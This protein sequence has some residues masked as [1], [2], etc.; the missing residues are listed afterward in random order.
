MSKNA[1]AAVGERAALIPAAQ[2]LR[3][4]SEVQKYS[5]F[6]Q[7]A[8]IA[9]FSKREGYEIVRTYVDE[10][11]SGISTKGRKGLSDMLADIVAGR[12]EYRAILVLDVSRWGRYQDP[13]EAAH[14]EFL[15]RSSGISVRYVAE[16]FDENPT[17]AILKQLK[18]VMAG[19]YSRELSERIRRAKRINRALGLVQGGSCPYGTA[20]QEL[21]PDGSL[22]KVLRRGE[23][24][25]HPEYR[26]RY[27]HGDEREIGVV[28]KIFDLYLVRKKLPAQIAR[29]LQRDGATW[30]SG[31]P[32]TFQHVRRVLT[33]EL[34]TGVLRFGKEAR[35]FGGP[36][37]IQP[38]S[39]WGEVRVMEP[40][41]PPRT[42]A[43]AQRR[44]A[45]LADNR[46]RS[47]ERMLSDLRRV[48]DRVGRLSTSVVDEAP[49]CCNAS[50]YDKRFGTLG[51]AMAL[52]GEKPRLNRLG[53]VLG[54]KIGEEQLLAV[55][56]RI[57]HERG[58]VSTS[59]LIKTPDAPSYM[60]YI[61]R[62]GSVAAACEA[63]GARYSRLRPG[64]A[65]LVP[66]QGDAAINRRS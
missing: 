30:T 66:V 15:C 22:G 25:S 65:A 10:G 20:R 2:Y 33:C 60:T 44:R 8:S 34:L 43:A 18:R 47:E 36:R 50:Y 3:A 64:P 52:I 55:L 27:V 12:A 35:P 32:I 63:A 62:F 6:H 31:E 57:E 54:R 37:T 14:Y 40:I 29:I 56:R 51:R 45:W 7:R 58:S 24:K 21:L 19:E 42:Y 9:E 5:S 23:R 17:G 53:S 39:T 16:A 48:R 61:K 49:E 11:K 26:L 4:S 38:R 41:V 46:R 1:E 59:L 28:R 13:D